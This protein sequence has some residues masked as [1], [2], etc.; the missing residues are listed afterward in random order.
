MS[1]PVARDPSSVAL[2]PRSHLPAVEVRIL[3]GDT[4]LEVVE[5]APPRPFYVG[6][7]S[8]SSLPVDFTLPDAALS[9][10]TVREAL[11]VVED[12]E[13]RVR[14]PKGAYALGGPPWE[15]PL[16][17]KVESGTVPLGAH[18]VDVH[19]GPL[20][21]SVKGG[22]KERVLPRT[23]VGADRRLVAFFAASL[24]AHGFIA[25]SLAYFAPPLGLTDDEDSDRNRIYLMQ[26]YLDASAER[27]AKPEPA[28]GDSTSG[29]ANAP[30]EPAKGTEGKMGRMQS[31]AHDHRASGVG[32]GA[33]TRAAVSRTEALQEAATFGMIGILNSGALASTHAAWDDMGVGDAVATGNLFGTTIGDSAGMNGL[34]LLG[35][36]EGGGGVS[37]QIGLGRIG[38][39]TGVDCAGFGKGRGLIMGKHATNVPRIHTQPPVTSGSLPPEVI[40]RV[41]RQSFGRFRLCYEEGLRG[42]PNLEGRVTARFVI[43]RDGSVATVQNGGADLPDARVVSC[44]LRAYTGLSFPAPKDGIVR[45]SYPLVFSPSA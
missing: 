11:V 20:V 26:Q 22:E 45:V 42:N 36:G 40:Q 12:G 4:T 1:H 23:G 27:E 21:F 31:P 28:D 9:E 24:F 30:D 43:G 41:V 19:W 33:E 10:E 37:N 29:A 5:L 16:A 14:V 38:T 34:G 32:A 18:G 44:V 7:A 17:A 35:L 6:D 15:R 2:K 3:W 8:R 25:G 13:A 39:C